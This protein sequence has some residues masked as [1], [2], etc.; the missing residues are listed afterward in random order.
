[1]H[2]GTFFGVTPRK[3]PYFAVRSLFQPFLMA[4]DCL[5]FF[6]VLS[7]GERFSARLFIQGLI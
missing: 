2:W 5:G 4:G 6:T 7:K 3:E 1:M